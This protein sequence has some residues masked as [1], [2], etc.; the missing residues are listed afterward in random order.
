M[1]PRVGSFVLIEETNTDAMRDLD[2]DSRC[3][4]CSGL[5]VNLQDID[6]V[7]TLICRY[8]KSSV[9][10]DAKVAGGVSATATVTGCL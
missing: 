7:A 4:E 8:D 10:S 2:T 3:S 6:I 1:E 9:G 5:R